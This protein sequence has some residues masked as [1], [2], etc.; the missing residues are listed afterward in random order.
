MDYKILIADDERIER[1]GIRSLLERKDYNLEILE[2]SNGKEALE[3]ARSQKPDILLSDIKKSKNEYI[4]E[5]TE[6]L[7][8]YSLEESI[9]IRN[10]QGEEIGKVNT[11]DNESS[12]RNLVKNNSSRF[13]KKKVYLKKEQEKLVVE[14]VKDI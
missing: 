4:V 6:Y 13:S 10:I 7:E 3:I 1:Q 2:A 12:I 5:I 11:N 8:D 9:I 14:K